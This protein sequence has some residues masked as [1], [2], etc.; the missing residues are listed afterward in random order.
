MRKADAFKLIPPYCLDIYTFVTRHVLPN[1][2]DYTVILGTL[3][4]STAIIAETSLTVSGIL[5]PPSIP[6]GGLDVGHREGALV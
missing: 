5:C 2:I 4:M 1:V 3:E 6:L